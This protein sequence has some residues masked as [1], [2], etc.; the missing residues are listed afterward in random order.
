[1]IGEKREQLLARI[2]PFYNGIADIR[3]IE[4]GDKDFGCIKP[5]PDND[6]L[7]RQ[8]V[9]SG[10]QCNTWNVRIAFVQSRKL[11]V[12]RPEIVPPL[13]NAMCLIDGKQGNQTTLI[14]LIHQPEKALGQ[15]SFWRDIDEV[16]IAAHQTPFNFK[17]RCKIKRGVQKSGTNPCLQ[18][19]VDLILHE[20]N[21]RRNHDTDARP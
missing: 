2:I 11:N 17:H 9:S 6:F 4:A 14:E 15:Q 13:R 12:F 10:R 1:M 7:S 3:A 8:F 20:C 16:K 18:Q 21:Q 5:K 19:G